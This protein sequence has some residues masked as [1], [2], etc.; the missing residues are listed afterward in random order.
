MNVVDTL[1]PDHGGVIASCVLALGRD[2][3][4]PAETVGSVNHI[5][6]HFA[7]IWIGGIDFT[8]PLAFTLTA[9]DRAQVV[10]VIGG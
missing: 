5:A 9:P 8:D 6:R 4:Q 1:C 3:A 2:I 10:I 7:G